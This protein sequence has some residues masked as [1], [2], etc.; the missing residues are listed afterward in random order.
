MQIDPN[1]A[2]QM[3]ELR[4][5]N[6]SG[7]G[8]T[9]PAAV[10]TNDTDQLFQLM[11]QQNIGT[12]SE[13]QSSG[14]SVQSLASLVS[15]GAPSS[16]TGSTYGTGST[17]P[18]YNF[19]QLPEVS[20][21]SATATARAGLTESS[22]PAAVSA[23]GD[24]SALQG[25]G[26]ADNGSKATAYNDLISTASSKYGIPESL[27]KAVIDVESS[28][29]PRAGSSAGAKGLM[30]L[31]DGTAAGLGVSNSYDPAQNIDGGTKYLSYQLKHFDNNVKTALA[32]YNAGPGRLQKL[33]I[34]NDNEL[35]AKFDQLPKET[36]RYISKIENAQSKYAL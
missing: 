30:Q 33:G 31:M 22:S 20:P 5:L 10:N 28:F 19:D 1:T 8:S 27:I 17:D 4:Y 9:T 32:A 21:E 34:S 13:A 3:L 16:V 26:G 14:A 35:M 7:G 29:N 15:A 11:L 2:K 12:S 24:T 25:I 23:G 6:A 18:W 36:Q